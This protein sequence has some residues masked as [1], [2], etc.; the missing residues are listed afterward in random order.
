MRLDKKMSAEYP[1]SSSH[2]WQGTSSA[3]R[4][5]WKVVDRWCHLSLWW[6][7]TRPVRI[8]VSDMKKKPD[9]ARL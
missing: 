5:S 6:M 1:V 2:Q 4:D 3:P 8:L 9:P 7:Q